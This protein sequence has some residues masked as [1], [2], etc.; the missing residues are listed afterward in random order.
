MEFEDQPIP[1][2]MPNPHEPLL[3]AAP[4][5]TPTPN[6]IIEAAATSD[7]VYP[8]TTTGEP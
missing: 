8:G 3:T 2:V 4:I 1:Q 7:D 6:V 5:M